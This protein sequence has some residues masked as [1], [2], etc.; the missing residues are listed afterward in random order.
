LKDRGAKYPE[1]LA[2]YSGALPRSV[3]HRSPR[4]GVLRSVQRNDSRRG[5]ERE[6]LCCIWHVG[7]SYLAGGCRRCIVRFKTVYEMTKDRRKETIERMLENVYSPLSEILRKAKFENDE[8]SKARNLP[9]FAW[10]VK[11]HELDRLRNIVERFGH[12][13]DRDEIAKFSKVLENPK[14]TRVSVFWL[15]G[16]GEVEMSERFEYIMKQRKDLMEELRQL[17]KPP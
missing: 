3:I 15:N 13:F 10:S 14:R 17:T 11:D 7:G 5:E 16:F 6:K 8:R 12:Y 4:R 9:G 1:H 2:Y